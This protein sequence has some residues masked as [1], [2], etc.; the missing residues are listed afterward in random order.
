M[1]IAGLAL[2]RGALKGSSHLHLS[3]LENTLRSPAT[4]FDTTPIGRI[5]NRFS[6]DIDMIDATLPRTFDMWIK[7]IIHVFSTIFVISFSTPLVLSIILPLG[8][9]YYFVQVLQQNNKMCGLNFKA[10]LVFS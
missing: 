7:C 4:F 5:V 9:V 2:A 8:I 1:F 10:S 6:K 3:I